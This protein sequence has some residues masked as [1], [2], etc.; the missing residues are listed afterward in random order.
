[1]KENKIALV[2]E[3]ENGLGIKFALILKN[4]G[5]DVI[6]AAK[7]VGYMQL[8]KMQL[9]GIHL[10]EI[11]L[12]KT[13]DLESLKVYIN[14]TY[15]KLDVLINNAE[16]TNGF[17]QK[18]NQLKIDEVKLLY[19]ENFFALI[20]TTQALY[21]LML[22]SEN[23]RIVNISSALGEVNKMSDDG[24]RFADYKMTAYSTAKASLEMLTVLLSKEFKGTNVEIASF[25]PIEAM[26]NTQNETEFCE[27]VKRGFLE[28]LEIKPILTL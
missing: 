14:N 5:F 15:G 17:G 1:M 18:I 4:E 9:E 26:R 25:N 11:D 20:S 23:A 12:T 13:E 7:G 8:E 21:P 6:L 27:K 2:T 16:I 24:Y 28:V 10:M 19:D 3:A 22:E